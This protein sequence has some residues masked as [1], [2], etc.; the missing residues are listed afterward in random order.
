M[1]KMIRSLLSNKDVS[2]QRHRGHRVRY[3]FFDR[4]V[5]IEEKHR[6]AANQRSLLSVLPACGR[7]VCLR[8]ESVF[9]KD[10]AGGKT[11]GRIKSS[12]RIFS[13]LGKT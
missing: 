6:H 2:P 8:G 7:Q 10:G 4:E 11:S 5:P 13:K 3:L 9:E 12:L 1:E